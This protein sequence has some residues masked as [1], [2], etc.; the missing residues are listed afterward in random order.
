MMPSTVKNAYIQLHISILL[1]GLTAILGKL[2]T[3]AGLVLVW[4]RILFTVGSFLLNPSLYADLK[5]LT[6]QQ[7]LRMAT[8]GTFIM[9]HWVCFYSSIKY[10]NASVTLSCL[11]TTSICTAFIDPLWNRTPFKWYEIVLGLAIIPGMALMYGFVPS[12]YY[13]GILLGFGAALFAAIFTTLN[14]EVMDGDT[15]VSPFAISFVELSF[16]FVGVSILMPIYLYVTNDSFLPST[17]VSPY[18]ANDYIWLVILSLA[19][20]TL[21]F[22][23]SLK[24]LKHLSAFTTTLSVNLEPVYGIILAWIIFQENKEL[25]TSFYI[26]IAM[27][28]LVV[29]LH[30]F[31]KKRFEK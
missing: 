6:R 11:A 28:L 1:W 22:I 10:S 30:P 31:L 20:T 25:G 17:T 8:I 12:S 26:G 19:C 7:I 16:G 5:R 15:T 3:L 13:F 14:K 21:P 4:W 23:L 18:G 9:L 2:I 24:A 29:G 27:V